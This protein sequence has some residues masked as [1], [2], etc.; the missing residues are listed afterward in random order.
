MPNTLGPIGPGSLPNTTVAPANTTLIYSSIPG[1]PAAHLQCQVKGHL[2]GPDDEVLEYRDGIGIAHC[3]VCDDRIQIARIPLGLLNPWAK[4]LVQ[5]LASR[6][7]AE[8]RQDFQRL[9]E[10]VAQVEERLEDL[11]SSLDLARGL[12]AKWS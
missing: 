12:L 1:P 2:V 5:R 6:P 11:R 7:D 10:Q 4:D 3:V 9:V 8:T